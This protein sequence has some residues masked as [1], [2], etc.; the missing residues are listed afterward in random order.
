MP[1]T[2][3]VMLLLCSPLVM[4][5]D[6]SGQDSSEML[7]EMMPLAD[8]ALLLDVS[9]FDGGHVAV[10][11][12]GHVLISSDLTDWQQAKIPTRSTLT[13]VHAEG[14]KIW[15]VGH[16]AVIVHSSDGGDTWVNQYAAPDLFQP[17]LDVYF[18][19]EQTGF[20][21]GA[22]G[23][24]LRTQNGGAD[25]EELVLNIVE[26]D[27]ESEGD[28]EDVDGDLTEDEAA[29]ELAEDDGFDSYD[30]S[31]FEDEIT[32]F[33]LNA[34]TQLASGD[35]YVAGET[36]NGLL[37]SNL[38]E[39]W[40]KVT[41]PYNGSMFGVVRTQND[42][43]VTFGLRGNVFKSVDQGQ[44]WQA[45]DT[46]VLDTLIGGISNKDGTVTLVGNNG[47]VL[48]SDPAITQFRTMVVDAAGDIA[49]VIQLDTN[50][51]VLVGENGIV[52]NG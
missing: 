38:G 50:R 3:T 8:R 52:N 39:S 27:A 29:D 11:D 24:M 21:M 26:A 5:Q 15:A 49:G 4:A 25:W 14:N 32:D 1:R 41:L 23:Y 6:G 31:D 33:H 43:L 45:I 48:I 42:A 46:G 20:A 34:M 47:R 40:T 12:R 19:D 13:S 37:S 10:G 35:L 7:A 28:S 16:D 44:T 9:P 51:F 17:L 30:F 2:L 22:Y 36:G 18:V